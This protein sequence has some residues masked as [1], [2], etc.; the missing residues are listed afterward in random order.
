MN[1]EKFGRIRLRKEDREIKVCS[2][3]SP[4]FPAMKKRVRNKTN[5]RAVIT[6]PIILAMQISFVNYTSLC[7]CKVVV[8]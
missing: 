2:L 6:R 8:Q 5:D 3:S 1:A 4:P 7:N